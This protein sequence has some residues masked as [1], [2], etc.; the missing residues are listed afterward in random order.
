[1]RTLPALLAFLVC[2]IAVPAFAQQAGTPID[3]LQWTPPELT[4]L[5]QSSAFHTD[6][7]FDRRMLEL[8]GGLWEGGDPGVTQ[9]IDK[10][11]GLAVHNYHY[12]GPSMY[13]PRM[14]DAVRHAYGSLGWE[15]MVLA[16]GAHSETGI[17]G[18]YGG[19][20]D[21]G[22]IDRSRPEHGATDLWVRFEHLQVTGAVVLFQSPNN[23]ALIAVSGN[24]SPIDLLRLRGH[25]GIP[26]FDGDH[27]QPQP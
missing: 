16:P 3:P 4:A 21:R 5:S 25:F 12:A 26:R 9:A 22:A 17:T 27:F 15:H 18:Q 6:L 8:A 13:D 1:M 14:V 10:L 20:T 19:G 7:T 2:S 11:N 23:V 24:L